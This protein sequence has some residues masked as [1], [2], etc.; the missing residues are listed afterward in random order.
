MAFRFPKNLSTI[1]SRTKFREYCLNPLGIKVLQL[2][3]I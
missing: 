3:V 1:A 2:I